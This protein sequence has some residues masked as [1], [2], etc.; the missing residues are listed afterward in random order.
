LIESAKGLHFSDQSYSEKKMEVGFVP[1][2]PDHYAQILQRF[3]AENADDCFLEKNV[4]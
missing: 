1:R 3:Q 2:F 4:I